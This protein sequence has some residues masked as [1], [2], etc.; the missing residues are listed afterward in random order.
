ML[1][2]GRLRPIGNHGR[3]VIFR[4][5][6]LPV[7]I[8]LRIEAVNFLEIIL[9]EAA[10]AAGIGIAHG[11]QKFIDRG[12]FD[13]VRKKAFFPSALRHIVQRRAAFIID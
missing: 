3:A 5:G 1:F 8:L 9:H 13:M 7:L 11:F 4:L 12:P 6:N 2:P 10:I